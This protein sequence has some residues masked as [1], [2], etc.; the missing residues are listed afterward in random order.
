LVEALKT[1]R[2]QWNEE[3]KAISNQPI[4]DWSSHYA[5]VF[6]YFAIV[7]KKQVLTPQEEA[8]EA[9]LPP[10][11]SYPLT[12]QDLFEDRENANGQR[13]AIR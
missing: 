1:Y 9:G 12:L 8:E 5:D 6:R 4:H 3:T 10:L 11:H 7:A 13:T 2:R